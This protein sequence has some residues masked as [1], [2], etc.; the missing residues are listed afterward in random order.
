MLTTVTLGFLFVLVIAG[1]VLTLLK[2]IDNQYFIDEKQQSSFLEPCLDA[3]N[4]VKKQNKWVGGALIGVGVVGLF[5][6]VYMGYAH[7][8]VGSGTPTSNFGFK[9]Y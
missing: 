3:L 1:G 5:M 6:T 2:G 4:K 9:F 7:N 8:V